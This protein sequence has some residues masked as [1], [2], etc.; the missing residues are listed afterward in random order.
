MVRDEKGLQIMKTVRSLPQ[1][2]ETEI[3]LDKWMCYHSESVS[4]SMSDICS[5]IL[6]VFAFGQDIEHGR[7][8]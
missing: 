6:P 3:E 1:D 5:Q 7:Y 2:I 4:D 8:E